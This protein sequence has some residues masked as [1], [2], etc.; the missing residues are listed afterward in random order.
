MATFSWLMAMVFEGAAEGFIAGPYKSASDDKIWDNIKKVRHQI[1]ENLLPHLGIEEIE[2]TDTFLRAKGFGNGT[3]Q[4]KFVAA[5]KAA[6]IQGKKSESKDPRKGILFVACDEFAENPQLGTALREGI[7]NNR[8]QKTFFGALGCNPKPGKIWHSQ[9]R[10]FSEPT[11]MRPGE[12]RRSIHRR[13]NTRSGICVRFDSDNSPNQLLG[14]DEFPYLFDSEN[15]ADLEREDDSERSAQKFAWA[16]GDE[17]A[18]SPTDHFR[19]ARAGVF[20]EWFWRDPLEK[21]LS[22]DPS[23]GGGDECV[24]TIGQSGIFEAVSRDVGERRQV[25]GV[26]VLRQEPIDMTEKSDFVVDEEF[27]AIARRVARHRQELEALKDPRAM[28]RPL[29][30]FMVER[31]TPGANVGGAVYV[32]VMAAQKCLDENVPWKNFIFDASQRADCADAIWKTF[33]RQNLRWFYEGTRR[34]VQEEEPD[35]VRWPY[36]TRYQG[37]ERVQEKWS[38][39]CSK[40]ISMLWFFGCEVLHSGRIVGGKACQ[41]GLDELGAREIETGRGGVK[42]VVSKKTLKENGM[43]SPAHG[44]TLAMLIYF[45]ARY[46]GAFDLGRPDEQHDRTNATTNPTLPEGRG[47]FNIRGSLVKRGRLWLP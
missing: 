46:M 30:E 36:V 10:R 45:A 35:W 38:D 16:F 2:V 29:E 5:D 33:G 25:R 24:F 41:K 23:F 21:V 39:V 18:E 42:D 28:D 31:L 4:I 44:E 15:A 22:L 17:G 13:W 20:D 7:A 6:A 8:G 12:M 1:N 9:M 26:A 3:A 40:V 19:Q 14:R 47:R 37:E 27:Y 43:K 34:L 32:A 11:D